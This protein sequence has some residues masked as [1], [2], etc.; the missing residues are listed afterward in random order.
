MRLLV[1]YGF[2]KVSEDLSVC[3][4]LLQETADLN[5]ETP[6]FQRLLVQYKEA[7]GR[8][9]LPQPTY[10]LETTD[11]E[12]KKEVIDM[13]SRKYEL[14][15]LWEK[16]FQI[17]TAG[18]ADD[19]AKTIYDSIL[20]LKKKVLK[21]MLDEAKHKIKEGEEQKASQ[22][23]ITERIMVF[24]ELK[25]YQVEIDRQLGIVISF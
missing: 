14:S 23:E 10:F 16:R 8:G 22:E 5:F 9:I 21:K 6:V 15:T 13:L 20:H 7:L 1:L 4:Y 3:Q 24:M 25:K 18:E 17:F 2:E 11:G 12:L 19:L